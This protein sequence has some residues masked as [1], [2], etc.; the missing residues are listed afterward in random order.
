MA[1]DNIVELFS[2]F[3]PVVVRRMF[4]GA[5]I[6]ADGTMFGL[7]ADG[8][9]YLKTGDSNAAMFEREQLLPF[10]FSKRTAERVVTS[11]R[12]MPDRLYDDTDELAVWARA[13]LAVAQQP[14]ARKGPAAKKAKVPRAKRSR[15]KALRAKALRAKALRAKPLRAK[16][17]RAKKA[18]SRNDRKR[19]TR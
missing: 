3:G 6:Y 13:A 16:P 5:G 9:I 10:T 11:Y 4:G 7:V 2:A 8:V 15:A 17:K 18:P 19:P 12:R 1:P 14:K